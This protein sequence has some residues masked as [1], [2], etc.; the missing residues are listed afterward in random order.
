MPKITGS[1]IATPKIAT[2]KIATSKI[3]TSNIIDVFGI[4]E[5]TIKCTCIDERT[6]T[7]LNH[8]LKILYSDKMREQKELKEIKDP[9]P[10]ENDAMDINDLVMRR[11]K[12][13]MET[14]KEI[15]PCK[16]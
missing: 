8:S 3:A 16:I 6:L 5:P 14:L 11:T 2:S 12:S 1:N 4:Y 9:S 15:K 10:L 13:L 7:N